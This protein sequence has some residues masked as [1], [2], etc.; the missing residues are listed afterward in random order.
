MS[1]DLIRKTMIFYLKSSLNNKTKKLLKKRKL[2]TIIMKQRSYMNKQNK[3]TTQ[4]CT[5][6][7][8]SVQNKL[9]YSSKPNLGLKIES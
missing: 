5:I 1:L 7:N 6:W 9:L 8:Y 3:L 2:K 4:I